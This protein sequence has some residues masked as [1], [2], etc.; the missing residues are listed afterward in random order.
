MRRQSWNVT[1]PTATL[2]NASPGGIIIEHSFDLRSP[3]QAARRK[4]KQ[5]FEQAESVRSFPANREHP[6]PEHLTLLNLSFHK[7]FT[8]LRYRSSLGQIELKSRASRS[9]PR[10]QLRGFPPLYISLAPPTWLRASPST[11]L[12]DRLISHFQQTESFYP[13]L[14][15]L[16]FSFL[17]VSIPPSLFQLSR[18]YFIGLFSFLLSSF[19]DEKHTF[20]ISVKYINDLQFSCTYVLHKFVSKKDAMSRALNLKS[21]TVKRAKLRAKI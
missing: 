13:L 5:I 4:N 9:I 18:Q 2:T 10:F 19:A 8:R 20:T 12:F 14:S 7:I 11:T 15:Y 1:T 21:K 3:S 16:L 6:W 17:L